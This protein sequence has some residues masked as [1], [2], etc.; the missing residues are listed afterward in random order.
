MLFPLLLLIQIPALNSLDRRPHDGKD[1][2]KGGAQGVY[3]RDRSCRASAK[4][5]ISFFPQE[6]HKSGG[7]GRKNGDADE[8]GVGELCGDQGVEYTR[9]DA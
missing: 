6:E 5:Q 3:L 8:G 4:A 9:E 1:E 7:Y 2:S